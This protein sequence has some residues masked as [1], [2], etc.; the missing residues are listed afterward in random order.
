MFKKNYFTFYS[1][2]KQNTQTIFSF[3]GENGRHPIHIHILKAKYCFAVNR[4]KKIDHMFREQGGCVYYIIVL[5]IKNHYNKTNH[6]CA[7]EKHR[8]P[9][10]ILHRLPVTFLR[11]NFIYTIRRHTLDV[12]S[13][14]F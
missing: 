7:L 10:K 6:I 4:T 5:E 2:G 13:I 9:S 12:L 11:C 14:P 3:A 1:M 8:V